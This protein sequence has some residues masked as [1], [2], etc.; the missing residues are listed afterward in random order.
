MRYVSFFSGVEMASLAWM[1]LGWQPL[2]F[3]ENDP[4]ASAGHPPA[5]AYTDGVDRSARQ[6]RRLTPVEC[7]R[8]QGVPDAHLDIIYRG[9]PAADGN[10]YKALGNGFATPILALIGERIQMAAAASVD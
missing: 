8:L 10:K 1:P 9:R 3:A 7:A 2:A 6:V 5:Y 4:F